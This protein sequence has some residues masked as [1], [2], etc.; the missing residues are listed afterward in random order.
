M[1]QMD[2][3]Q[4]DELVN[5]QGATVLDRDGER[6]GTIE[7]LWVNNVNNLPEWAAVKTGKLLGSMSR[8]V[9]LRAAD[10][11]ETVTVAYTKDEVKSSPQFEPQEASK[12][13]IEAL[14]RHYRQPLPAPAPPKVRNP[15]D[16][17]TAT[18]VPG[19]GREAAAVGEQ[20][21]Q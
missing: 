15:F 6:I 18:W 12:D 1:P 19:V 3:T 17:L 11:S 7:Q 4:V 16:R 9:P 5:L 14:Y 8:Y 20:Y 13:D 21:R 2:L 10:I